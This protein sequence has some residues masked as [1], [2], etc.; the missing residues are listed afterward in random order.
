MHFVTSACLKHSTRTLMPEHNLAIKEEEN[1]CTQNQI[2]EALKIKLTSG[3]PAD[4]SIHSK[5]AHELYPA[6]GWRH[7]GSAP[8]S[9]TALAEERG[10]VPGSA[11]SVHS[12]HCAL[13]ALCALSA[14]SAPCA[15]SA[16]LALRAPRA[17]QALRALRAFCALCALC[18]LC[19]LG[20]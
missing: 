9:L 2:H 5:C 16:P 14:L 15:R 13:C 18:A 10:T 12:V 3:A 20:F 19:T 1:K 8:F 6:L 7:L 11:P 4:G 17:L